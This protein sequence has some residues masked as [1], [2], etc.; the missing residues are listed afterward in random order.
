MIFARLAVLVSV[1]VGV[2]FAVEPYHTI[3]VHMEEGVVG[4]IRWRARSV[5][6]LARRRRPSRREAELGRRQI[7]CK[8]VLHIHGSRV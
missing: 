7:Q 5:D 8:K 4:E 3:D 6:C 1:V 2:A